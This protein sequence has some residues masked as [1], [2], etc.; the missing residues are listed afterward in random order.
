MEVC[1]S[2]GRGF[3]VDVCRVDGTD[4]GVVNVYVNLDYI[5]LSGAVGPQK[6][7]TV[8]VSTETPRI[9]S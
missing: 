7:L 5:W 2:L 8:Q 3:E 4:G 1:W 6:D 9:S